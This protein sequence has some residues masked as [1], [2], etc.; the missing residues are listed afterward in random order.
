[1]RLPTVYAHSVASGA[2]VSTVRDPQMIRERMSRPRW[3][4]PSQNVPGG[5]VLFP[6]NAAPGFWYGT[7]VAFGPNGEIRGASRATATQNRTMPAPS[8]PTQLSRRRP[9]DRSARASAP[10]AGAG[11]V[12]VVAW[13]MAIPLRLPEPDARV[14]VRGADV[15]ECLRAHRDEHGDHRAGLDHE[16][17]LVERGLE[18]ERAEPPVGEI[19]LDHD[20]A[21]Q[22][23]ADL[24]HDH[25]EGR[26]EGVAE[27]VLQDHLPVGQP[28][29]HGGADVVRGHDLGHRGPR[30]PRHVAEIVEHEHQ[31]REEQLLQPE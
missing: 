17:V 29:E 16:D 11:T 1:M 19:G 22:E 13:A 27:G 25:G 20:D 24:E 3:S 30:H 18:E 12:S 2:Y 10:D 4:V 28:L 6:G 23:P 8:M 15:G 14:E 26:D 5:T 21:G 31:D 9:T 7:S